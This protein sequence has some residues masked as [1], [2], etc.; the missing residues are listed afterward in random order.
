LSNQVIVA[1]TGMYPFSKKSELTADLM[2]A[3]AIRDL[4]KEAE[5]P[6]SSVDEVYV[7]SAKA[8]GLIGQR[9]LRF[10]GLATGMPVFNVEN[11]CASSGVAFHLAWRAVSAGQI[12]SA[13]VVGVDRLS[14]LGK[15]T[16]PVQNTEW[17]GKAGVTNPVVYAMRAQRYMYETD[18]V[19]EDLAEV[20]VK[21]RRFAAHNPHAQMK[22]EVTIEEVLA[23]KPVA[24]PLT[25]FQCSPKSD[26]ASALLLVGEELAKRHGVSGPRVRSS[27]VKS[28]A[29]SM[30]ERD[31][32]RPDITARTAKQ[33]FESAGIG[34]DE[35]DVVELHDAF[36]IAELLYTEELGLAGEGEGVSYLRSGASARLTAGKGAV[37]NPSGGLLSRGHPIGAT[38]C[39]QIVECVHQL[40]GRSG[41]RQRQGARMALAH[42]TGGGA[43]GFDNGACAVTVLSVD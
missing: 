2:A 15:G 5:F 10:A 29:F 8:G 23:S 19:A 39:A 37:V 20:S 13:L 32:T 30:G 31:I 3:S 40:Q 38:G 26:G 36:S 16:L 41:S 42:V 14:S 12:E 25:L 17:D 43:S 34:P 33:A 9:A 18:A 1:G 21:S 11:A 22:T 28:G 4:A 27:V 35:L 6:L 7:G 24:D